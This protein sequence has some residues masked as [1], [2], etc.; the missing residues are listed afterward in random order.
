[1][2]SAQAGGLYHFQ[3]WYFYSENRLSQP[4]EKFKGYMDLRLESSPKYNPVHVVWG[5]YNRE[6]IISWGRWWGNLYQFG[7]VIS[8]LWV[9]T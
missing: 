7:T 3:S 9:L 5:T 4:G 6:F 1:M 2:G 8:V